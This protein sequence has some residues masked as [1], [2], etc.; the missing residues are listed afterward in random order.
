MSVIIEFFVAPSHEAAAAVVNGGPCGVFASL[1][2]G[3]FDVEEALIEWET[4]FT[5]RSHDELVAAGEHEAVADPGGGGPVVLVVSRPLQNALAVAGPS[6]LIDVC[7]LWV[8]TR[9]A[10]GEV[11]DNEIVAQLLR[12]LA[13]LAHDIGRR[14]HRLYCWLA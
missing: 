2:S 3:N 4:I 8:Q 6:R 10:D 1:S 13:R 5:G 11:L 14:G 12:D 7:R 9:A